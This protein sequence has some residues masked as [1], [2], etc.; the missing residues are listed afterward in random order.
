MHIK[1]ILLA[2]LLATIG[3]AFQANATIF[4]DWSFVQSEQVIAPTDIARFQATLTNKA[5]SDE[6]LI[7]NVETDTDDSGFNILGVGTGYAI[8]PLAAIDGA[9]P[10]QKPSW[11][12]FLG[13]DL[14][15]GESFTFDAFTFYPVSGSAPDG[16]VLTNFARLEV[17]PNDETRGRVFP[18]IA[19]LREWLVRIDANVTPTPHRPYPPPHL[20]H[21][22]G[23]P[24]AG[25]TLGLLAL[26]LGGF[27]FLRRMN[28]LN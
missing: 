9:W 19:I 24:D 11:H 12:Q 22:R 23:V 21:P 18:E 17:L 5:T 4:Y 28:G 2:S 10:H 15:P 25:S 3:A 27:G 26:A 13:L 1:S 6:N 16:F 7:F 8:G 14:A 20:V